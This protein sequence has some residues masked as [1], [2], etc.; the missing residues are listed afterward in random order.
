MWR[1]QPE[2]LALLELLVRGSLK[3]RRAQAIAWDALAELSWTRRAGRRDEIG[4]VESR[5]PELVALEPGHTVACHFADSTS[6]TA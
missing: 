6:V 2:R 3:R 4:L 5:R 1:D